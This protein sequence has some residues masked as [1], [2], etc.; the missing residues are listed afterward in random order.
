[1]MIG[2]PLGNRYDP[3]LGTIHRGLLTAFGDGLRAAYAGTLEEPLPERLRSQA[4]AIIAPR[5]G[6]AL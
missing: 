6:R 1:M 5:R 2:N 4:E 3:A